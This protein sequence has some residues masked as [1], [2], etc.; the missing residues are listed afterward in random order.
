MPGDDE[1]SQDA[2]RD[3][4]QRRADRGN[5]HAGLPAEFPVN[6]RAVHQK[7]QRIDQRARAEDDAEVLLGHQR[8]QRG[9]GDDDVV[10]AH[11]QK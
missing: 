4:G 10:T 2:E 1:P 8:A 7:R 11:A 3:V 5:Q 9:L 6:E